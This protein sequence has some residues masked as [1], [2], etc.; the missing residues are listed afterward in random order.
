MDISASDLR[1][2][3]GVAQS[4]NLS[5]A[6]ER[7]GISQPSLTLAMQRLEH[8]IGAPLLIRSRKGATLTAAGKHL[9]RHARGL[10][11]QWETL[12]EGTLSAVQDV[13]GVY[14]IGCH[15][16]M[17][18]N[19]FRL[20]LGDLLA[21]HPNLE[22]TLKHDVSRRVAEDVISLRT[23]IGIVVNPVPH[24]DLIIT[25][26][27]QDEVTIWYQPAMPKANRDVLIC[28]PDLLQTQEIQRKLPKA[29][30]GFK[31]TLVSSNLEV[32]AELTAAGC[33]YGILPSKVAARA[34]HKLTHL[35]K[36][37][38]VTDR[39][40]LIYR[41]ENKNIQS[42]RALAEAIKGCFDK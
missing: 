29:G 21:K 26:L 33:G 6:A 10:I 41:A 31:R 24:P 17:A 34:M 39:H 32:I 22:V 37:P 40:C 12:R 25:P 28:D 2:F 38:A 23:D 19:I 13:G 9:H 35:P 15:P 7:L 11:E 18:R 27:T 3:L 14:T 1:Y 42:I 30:L 16:S 8:V 20:F 5:R 36:A 4:E